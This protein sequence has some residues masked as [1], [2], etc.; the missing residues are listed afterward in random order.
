MVK[1]PPLFAPSLVGRRPRWSAMAAALVLVLA[2][3]LTAPPARAG[4]LRLLAGAGLRQPTD[5]L[6][7]AFE[8]QTGIKV[9]VD[10]GGSG[11]VMARLLMSK[12]G[13]LF[14]PGALFY[15]DK[16]RAKGMV[17][18]VRRIVLHT[19]VLAVNRAKA[20]L[21]SSLADLAKP[22]LKVG[23]GDPKAMALGR[24]A[25]E[26]LRK[27]GLAE[28]VAPNVV[29]H[30]ATVKQLAMYLAEGYVDAAI[31]ARSDAFLQRDKM[32]M[33]PIPAHLHTPD[34][35]GAA[36]LTTSADPAAARRLQEFL[37]SPQGRQ[38]FVEH[39]FLPLPAGKP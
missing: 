33:I 34:V 10:Y 29:V 37:G 14:M 30:T 27:A 2:L 20:D 4:E 21:V 3:L 24:L 9:L 32:K 11:Q 19:P 18:S 5:Q 13:D 1:P 35:I 25:E 23:L 39:G 6:V 26:I 15:I 31:I 22:G 16:L 38:V 28:R 12:Q 17:V 36:L 7:R 8:Q